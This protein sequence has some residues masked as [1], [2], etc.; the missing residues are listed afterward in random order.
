MKNT[1]EV[2]CYIQN[3]KQE[4]SFYQVEIETEDNR[5]LILEME[6]KENELL[7]QN[8]FSP[9]FRMWHKEEIIKNVLGWILFSEQRRYWDQFIPEK[10]Y[11]YKKKLDLEELY[12]RY[13]FIHSLPE[14]EKWLSKLHKS[15]STK[16]TYRRCLRIFL[17]Y[18]IQN[19]ATLT[20]FGITDVQNFFRELEK[21]SEFYV[22]KVYFALLQFVKYQ[23]PELEKFFKEMVSIP[24]PPKLLE[25]APKALEQNK[26]NEIL[27][28]LEDPLFAARGKGTKMRYFEALRNLTIAHLLFDTGLRLSELTNLNVD[29]IELGKTTKT[30]KI[31]IKGKRN[32]VRYIPIPNNSR[33][34]LEE[35]LNEREW[36]LKEK[37]VEI[38][39]VF[40][41]NQLKRISTRTVYRIF[42]K[43]DTH[44]HATRHTLLTKLVRKGVDL[45]TVKKIAGH[46]NINTTSRYSKPTFEELASVLN[47]N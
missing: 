23:R 31:R 28:K 1:F 46:A 43:F 47:E 3:I 45:V 7:I 9:R 24:A 17:K 44:P 16:D 4:G 20:N 19:G 33:K 8:V 32:K 42:E 30:S 5:I 26:V 38:D 18:C 22:E 11:I 21:K 14:I 35:Y 15:E 27:R 6:E 41:S 2:E 40:I 37:N 36:L 34:W 10:D 13:R 25:Y 39:A 12:F 29:D